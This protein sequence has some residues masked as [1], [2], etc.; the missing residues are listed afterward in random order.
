[1]DNEI[2]IILLIVILI[3]IILLFLITNMKYN[4]PQPQPQPQLQPYGGCTGT[5]YGCCPGGII[6]KHDFVGSNCLY[7]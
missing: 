7:H 6:A 5:I 2:I 4:P 3:L 1:M